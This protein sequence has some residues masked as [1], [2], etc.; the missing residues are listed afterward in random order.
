MPSTVCK[1][2][3]K[4]KAAFKNNTHS[5]IDGFKMHAKNGQK[6]GECVNVQGNSGA[7]IPMNL[8]SVFQRP[9]AD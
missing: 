1:L 6:S 5:V 8:R 9:N 4:Y 3:Q 7:I 2:K